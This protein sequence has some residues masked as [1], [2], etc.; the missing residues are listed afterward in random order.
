MT[1]ILHVFS[2]HS[3]FWYEIDRRPSFEGIGSICMVNNKERGVRNACT[4]VDVTRR[5]GWSENYQVAG[6]RRHRQH[7]GGGRGAN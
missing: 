3:T 1:R 4:G 7:A 6:R 2:I 5:I